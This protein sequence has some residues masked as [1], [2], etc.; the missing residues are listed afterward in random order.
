MNHDTATDRH[1]LCVCLPDDE[2]QPWKW[3]RHLKRDESGPAAGRYGYPSIIQAQDGTLHVTDSY[4]LSPT[5]AAKDSAAR[6]RRE[7]IQHAHFNEA[8]ISAGD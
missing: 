7:T 4:A 1:R 8:W 3:S 6:P 2:G 5:N